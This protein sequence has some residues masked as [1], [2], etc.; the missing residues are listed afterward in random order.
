MRR[1]EELSVRQFGD[2]NPVGTIHKVGEN[3]VFMH[4]DTMN[5]PFSR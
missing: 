2:I 1:R 4:E 5:S 3:V